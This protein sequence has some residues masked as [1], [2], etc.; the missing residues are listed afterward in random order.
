MTEDPERIAT[1]AGTA[2]S[3]R[4]R[5]RTADI[6]LVAGLLFLVW[7]IGNVLLLILAGVVLAV[8]LDG[9]ASGLARHTPLSRGIALFLVCVSILGALVGVGWTVAPQVASQFQD[10]WER[11]TDLI[12]AGIEWVDST[13][14][15]QD[16]LGDVGEGGQIIGAANQIL[17]MVAS[18][19]ITTFEAVTSVA[20]LI[21]LGIFMAVNPVLYYNGL[22]RLTPPLKRPLI[23]RTLSSIADALRWW[24]LAQLVSMAILGISIG[25]GL[26][27]IGI[28]LWL[29]LAVITALLTFIPYLGPIIAGIPTVAIG[30]AD[31]YE[32]G[33][34]VLVFFLVVQNIESNVIL[35]LVYQKAIRL[36]P[37]VAIS[38]Q[39]FF[40]L[41][42]G[43]AG[44]ILAAPVTV[45][46]MVAL[47]KLYVEA[48]LGEPHA[49]EADS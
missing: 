12:D 42:F 29:A 37:A 4:F 5:L 30:F 39:V 33:L 46:I 49:A 24:F 16:L 47:E 10:L 25:I 13:G 48:A 17:A 18:F 41:V 14:W 1:T 6:L 20:I 27:V 8:G 23:A 9:L 21:V 31:S 22:L 35:P 3:E 19:G 45:V 44:F 15:S 26:Y 32:T 34:I 7:A 2:A 28:E 36:P 11:L 38:A 40:G 43:V